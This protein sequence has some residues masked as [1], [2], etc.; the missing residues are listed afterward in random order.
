MSH[1]VR[2]S[3]NRNLSFGET[4]ETPLF[5]GP[6]GIEPTIWRNPIPCEGYRMHAFKGQKITL[7]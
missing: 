7:V 5:W 6:S 3:K 4:V 1:F 2:T